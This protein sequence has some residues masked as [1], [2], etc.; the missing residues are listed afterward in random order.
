MSALAPIVKMPAAA[1]A[2]A[3]TRAEVAAAETPREAVRAKLKAEALVALLDATVKAGGKHLAGL[4][5]EAHW[6]TLEAALALGEAVGSAAS[7]AWPTV[8]QVPS[9]KLAR[10]L[11]EER[12]ALQRVVVLA[13][14]R[15]AAPTVFDAI[16][17]A[18]IREGKPVP[19]SKLRALAPKPPK[20]EPD[21]QGEDGEDDE[22]KDDQIAVRVS[23]RI[24]KLVDDVRGSASRSDW[25]GR[26]V[27]DAVDGEPLLRAR[28]LTERALLEAKRVDTA[29][30]R[31]VAKLLGEIAELEL[32][33]V[34]AT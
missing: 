16:A 1:A 15:R 8:N 25:A 29:L 20:D 10:E 4:H 13:F 18:A 34:D 28:R 17:E 30:A 19:W 5:R 24:R 12:S 2:V 33:G 31:R 6:L 22:T 21:D 32:G 9:R 11:G 23:P 14:A 27:T 3:D 26:L 7:E